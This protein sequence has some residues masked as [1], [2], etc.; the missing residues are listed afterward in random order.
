MI[1]EITIIDLGSNLMVVKC[2]VFHAWLT[3]LVLSA[4]FLSESATRLIR[5]GVKLIVAGVSEPWFTSTVPG[6]LHCMDTIRSCEL[7]SLY[8]SGESN[9]HKRELADS[10]LKVNT[11][12]VRTDRGRR[13]TS[14][15][16]KNN[17]T[18][19]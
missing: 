17:T 14:A 2:V 19:V 1:P 7:V 3:R 13:R 11:S 8:K 12:G 6:K 9:A 5:M 10:I 15:N 4:V 16:D 18:R